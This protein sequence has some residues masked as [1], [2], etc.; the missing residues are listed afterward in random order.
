M[1]DKPFKIHGSA[2]HFARIAA[3]QAVYQIEQNPDD[4]MDV[5]RQFL[6]NR[7]REDFKGST[8]PDTQLFI[9]IVECLQ[10]NLNQFDE[11]ISEYLS[12]GWAL[13]RLPSLARAVLRCAAYELSSELAVPVPVILNEYAEVAKG[14]LDQKD[15]NFIHGVLHNIAEKLR[16]LSRQ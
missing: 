3:V 10:K 16:S 13:T 8:E 2:R 11:I 7:F 15:V 6:Q 5:V 4:K 14:F 12:E 1:E 9:T